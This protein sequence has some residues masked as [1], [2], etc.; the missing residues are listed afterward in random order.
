VFSSFLLY[1]PG[2]KS[3]P[4]GG[5]LWGKNLREE[6]GRKEIL[7]SFRNG[8]LG[9]T[10]CPIPRPE[11]DRSEKTGGKDTAK[12]REGKEEESN[13]GGKPSKGGG[14]LFCTTASG[15]RE[16]RQRDNRSRRGKKVGQGEETTKPGACPN[17]APASGPGGSHT[18]TERPGEGEKKGRNNKCVRTKGPNFLTGSGPLWKKGLRGPRQGGGGEVALREKEKSLRRRRGPGGIPQKKKKKQPEEED[19]PPDRALQSASV[20]KVPRSRR[21]LEGE[22]NQNQRKKTLKEKA[23]LGKV[24]GTSVGRH[25]PRCWETFD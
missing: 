18:T 21:Q 5:F 1:G 17:G 15:G 23:G 12:T 11:G 16:W 7:G 22:K 10:R 24:Q 14:T 8:L 2:G 25:R 3:W 4:R 13:R 19:A 20:L 6:Q 9:G